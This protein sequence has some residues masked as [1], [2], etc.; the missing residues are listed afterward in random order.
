[1]AYSR[2]QLKAKW[3][4]IRDAI[5]DDMATNTGAKLRITTYSIADQSYSYATAQERINLLNYAEQQIQK[6]TKS[7]M[8][9]LARFADL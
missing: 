9:T 6:Y 3:Q 2:A 4:Q 8:F 1:M 5:I 7:G